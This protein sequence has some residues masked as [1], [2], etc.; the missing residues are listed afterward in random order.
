[1]TTHEKALDAAQIAFQERYE[2]GCDLDQIELVVSAYLSALLPEDVA[3]LVEWL[4]DESIRL[5]GRSLDYGCADSGIAAN[6]ADEAVSLI[7]SQAARIAGLEAGL[8]R[9]ANNPVSFSHAA[10]QAARSLLNK[11]GRG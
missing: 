7:Q 9:I 8:E 5:S 10:A 1:M 6:V 11:E 2:L 3:G 4:R